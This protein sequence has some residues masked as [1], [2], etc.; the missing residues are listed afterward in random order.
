MVCLQVGNITGKLFE[1]LPVI[2]GPLHNRFDRALKLVREL[3]VDFLPVRQ[4]AALGIVRHL[5]DDLVQLF[6]EI[7]HAL[8]GRH[9]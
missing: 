5:L 9:N 7:P 6:L 2:L 1:I 8:G 4:E 3:L